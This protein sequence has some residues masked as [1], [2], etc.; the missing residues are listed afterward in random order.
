MRYRIYERPLMFMLD[1][2]G[3]LR[4]IERYIEGCLAKQGARHEERLAKQSTLHE[5]RLAKLSAQHDAHLKFFRT[6]LEAQD[7][8]LRRLELQQRG[9]AWVM[10][11]PFLATCLC[12]SGCALL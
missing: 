10:S 2:P 12:G 9:K 4:S 11:A 5:E 8:H 3:R 6:H 1:L 7:L